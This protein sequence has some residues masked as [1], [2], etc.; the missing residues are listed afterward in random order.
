M[1][2]LGKDSTIPARY[3]PEIL[4]PIPRAEARER[5]GIG[6]ELPFHGEDVW[7]GWE[8]SWLDA[9]S[10]PCC[11]V[12]RFTFPATSP[13]LVE[14][15]S[16]KLYLNSLNGE[17]FEST[18]SLSGTLVA[19]LSGVAGADVEVEILAV[20]DPA[21]APMLLPGACIDGRRAARS[22]EAP[23]AALLQVEAAAG[24]VQTV[25]SHGMRSLCPVTAQPDWATVILTSQ[26]ALVEPASL[27]AYIHAFRGHQE[28]HEQCVERMFRDLLHAGLEDFSVQALYT[29]RGGMDINPWR[30][31]GPGK[32]PRL[33]G[34]RQ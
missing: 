7:H 31:T 4:F 24:E 30:S 15:K 8:L 23:D 12:G 1:T 29:R 27:L 22:A 3:A 28:Y 13:N 16:F 6:A 11:A 19:D 32:A 10:Q 9:D 5:L 20:D 17:R 21:L 34:M 14:S 18:L 2:L 33:R 26:D 25:Y